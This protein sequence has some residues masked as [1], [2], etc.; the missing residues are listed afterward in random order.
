MYVSVTATTTT[1]T[2]RGSGVRVRV[3]PGSSCA[4]VRASSCQ[5]LCLVE[6]APRCAQ[7]RGCGP[8]GFG[9]PLV[10]RS[11]RDKPACSENGRAGSTPRTPE[12]HINCASEQR[13]PT[14]RTRSDSRP[15]A[16]GR[17]RRE[18]SVSQDMRSSRATGEVGETIS[19]CGIMH[20]APARTLIST[21]A[22]PLSYSIQPVEVA[23][24]PILTV[25]GGG[26]GVAVRPGLAW[27]QLPAGRGPLPKRLTRALQDSGGTPLHEPR[28]AFQ[29]VC[30]EAPRHL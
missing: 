26:K 20:H 6:T 24:D 11:H 16:S 14:S 22:G 29:S 9:M 25:E 13:A 21:Y 18:A 5:A 3:F 1:T 15:W 30:E 8:C 23:Q 10:G 12:R 4:S 19:R 17:A 2:K 7:V 28:P 27:A